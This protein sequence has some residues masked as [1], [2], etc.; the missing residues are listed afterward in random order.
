[1]R[2]DDVKPG[3]ACA[4]AVE[5]PEGGNGAAKKPWADG[6]TRK[7]VYLHPGQAVIASE[8]SELTTVLGSCVSVCLFDPAAEV[9]GMNHY[10]LPLEVEREKSLRYGGQAMEHLLAGVL[11]VGADRRRLQAKVFGGASVIDAFRHRNLGADNVELALHFL[12]RLGIPVIER[13]VGERGGR[14][15]VFHT[16]S[17]AAWVKRL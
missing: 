14:K 1:V 9:G 4:Q 10:L 7:T 12:E 16:D 17:G 11:G 6:K 15:V 2:G 5:S 3:N 8:P 13:D